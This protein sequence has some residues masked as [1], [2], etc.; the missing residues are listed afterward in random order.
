[1][2]HEEDAIVARFCTPWIIIYK[3]LYLDQKKVS[4]ASEPRSEV[5]IGISMGL[6]SCSLSI[7]HVYSGLH[8]WLTYSPEDTF[9]PHTMGKSQN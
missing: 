7:I 4:H 3:H 9:A 2:I 5:S 8:P 6:R 1:M